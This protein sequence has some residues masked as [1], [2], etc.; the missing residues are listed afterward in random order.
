MICIVL[1]AGDA[2]CLYPLTENF[3]KPLLPVGDK[4]ILNW[5]LDD[6]DALSQIMWYVITS[7]HKFIKHFE[8]WQQHY[9]KPITLLDNGPTD[10]D[11]HLGVLKDIQY[12]IELLNVTEGLLTITEYN[13]LGFSFGQFTRFAR[14]KQTFC[15]MCD[16][17]NKIPKQQ[18]TAILTK[19]EQ[20]SII[21][22]EKK[23]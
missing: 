13:I 20:N 2:T 11:H 10:N 17:E 12:A 8:E 9:T 23:P 6:I 19:D 1:A 4:P 5:L 14:E 21:A 7:N 15:V 22:Y 3:P 16:E 18:R